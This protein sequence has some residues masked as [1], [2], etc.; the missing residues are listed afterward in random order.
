MSGV[1][2]PAIRA[3][4]DQVVS[5]GHGLAAGEPRVLGLRGQ[6]DPKLKGVF[7]HIVAG[8]EVNV[9]VVPCVSAL[10]AREALVD[11]TGDDWLVLVT[12]RDETDL[13][14][15]IIGHLIGQRLR[16]IDPWLGVKEAFGA[17]GIDR[18][19]SKLPQGRVVAQGLLSVLEEGS[20]WPAA[21]AGLLTLDHVG[22][23]LARRVLGM[24][25]GT[26]DGV[27][28][29]RWAA[30]GSARSSTGR[31]E[32]SRR[33]SGPLGAVNALAQLRRL[34]GD[35]LV[36]SLLDWLAGRCGAAADVV[37]A[38][39]H[40]ARPARLVPLGVAA[41]HL[42]EARSTDAGASAAWERFVET[43]GMA[44]A[45]PGAADALG[46]IAMTVAGDLLESNATWAIGSTLLTE[47]DRLL[48]DVGA[49][50]VAAQSVLL[51]TGLKQ[52]FRDLAEALRSEGV[53]G[54]HLLTHG[55]GQKTTA[56]SALT[57]DTAWQAVTMHA[58]VRLAPAR[59][60]PAAFAPSEAAVRLHRWLALAPTTLQQPSTTGQASFAELCRQH[61]HQ[62]AWVDS[63]I[64]DAAGGAADLELSTALAAVVGEA[65]ARR[66]AADRAFAAEL[67]RI[68]Q[69]GDGQDGPLTG[70]GDPVLP[71]E[72]VLR[73]VIALVARTTPTLLIV[74]DGMTARVAAE[75]IEDVLAEGRGWV[76]ALPRGVA[77]RLAGLA[78]LPTLTEH[79]RTSLLCGRL[80]SG[81]QQTEKKE[82]PAVVTALGAGPAQIFHKAELDR[83]PD[84]HR[85]AHPVRDALGD[86]SV[87]LVTCVLNTIDDALDRSDP[88]GIDWR[89]DSVKHLAALL[90]EAA[91][92]GRAVVLTSDHGHVL[93]RRQGAKQPGDATS[94]RSR[95]MGEGVRDGEVLVG[96]PRVLGGSPVVLAV[97]DTVRYSDLRAGYHGGGAAAE[98]VVPI[99]L[100]WPGA[101]PNTS[102]DPLAG[103]EERPFPYV[104]A[105]S[106]R[107]EWWNHSHALPATPSPTLTPTSPT[108]AP[109]GP[110]QA[111]VG[112]R[113]ATAGPRRTTVKPAQDALTGPGHVIVS[114]PV[115]KA[116]R[117]ISGR[118]TL[119]DER[120]AR[121][122]D[123]LM[124]AP[125]TR[126][127]ATAVAGVLGIPDVR[128]QGAISQLQK[129]LNVEGYPVIRQDQGMLVLDPGLLTEQFALS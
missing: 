4:I 73:E 27:A 19:L 76:E 110:K 96:G 32:S 81:N 25:D 50:A 3:E 122:I 107:P 94:A 78:V 82:H 39:L 52:R 40:E 49:A 75:I 23:A 118:I 46:A 6:P 95:H 14:A 53:H 106:Q 11:R 127:A 123:E 66:A 85:L 104:E 68:T 117:A 41:H 72:H 18:S 17:T 57:V 86:S 24:H 16:Q 89:L 121:L 67:A 61:L 43:Q 48:S 30:S 113:R 105:P 31:E 125:G 10:A 7:R 34:G 70:D 116:Q 28:V 36:E 92:V 111:P 109:A 20:E 126:L 8:D 108:M 5:K 101:V 79:S 98:A 91:D 65:R 84:G 47:A 69:T 12:D 88:E 37:R 103:E 112:P 129:L 58:L 55:A 45:K 22:A 62:D 100:L 124:T 9:Q 21:P 102:G 33:D 29:L 71:L 77:R 74:L 83:V 114:G 64:H 38:E 56:Q 93:E 119:D 63:A 115:W 120:C 2:T 80:T 42:R 90:E 26:I 44:Y 15:G 60:R 35:P 54:G 97:D 87:R 13:G 51:P 99:V 128:A 59:Q 1:S